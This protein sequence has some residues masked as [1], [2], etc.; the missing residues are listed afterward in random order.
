MEKMDGELRALERARGDAYVRLTEQVRLL[1][2]GQ[3]YLHAETASLVSALRAPAVRGRWGE[4]QLRRVVEMVGMVEHCDFVEQATAVTPDGR[5][6]PD[7][8]VRLPAGVSVVVDAKAPLVAYLEAQGAA[9][10]EQRAALL[11]QHAAQVRAHVQKLGSKSYWEQFSPS[12]ELVVLFL[13]GE[14]F[15]SAALQEAPDLIEEAYASRVLVATP[16]TLIGVLQA[17]HYGWRQERVAANAEELARC[18]RELHERLATLA[19]HFVGLGGAIGRTVEVFNKVAG[20]FEARV[21]PGARRLEELGAHGKKDL[22]DIEPVDRRPRVL[23]LA[24]AL[25]EL[26]AVTAAEG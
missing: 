19:E 7:L 6:R 20:S 2:D 18:G 4:I 10:E 24:P 11:R 15:Y 13:P 21:L 8:V 16:T 9:S 25:P 17:I 26:V 12:P 23:A 3:K 22:P 5:L 1:A 14:A